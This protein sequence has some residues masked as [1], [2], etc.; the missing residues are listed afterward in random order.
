MD[1]ESPPSISSQ[2]AKSNSSNPSATLFRTTEPVL[3][4]ALIEKKLGLA[5]TWSK[6]RLKTLEIRAD[7]TLWV[8]DPGLS[9]SEDDSEANNDPSASST[10]SSSVKMITQLTSTITNT[11]TSPLQTLASPGLSSTV[12]YQLQKLHLTQM[13]N[14]ALDGNGNE[15]DFGILLDLTSHDGFETKIRVILNEY[16]L[17]DFTQA[18]HLV[19]VDHNLDSVRQLSITEHVTSETDHFNKSNGSNNGTNANNGAKRTKITTTSTHKHKRRTISS[20]TAASASTMRITIAMAMDAVNTQSRVERVVS[21]R[22]V[23]KWLPVYFSNDL[24]H[25]AWYVT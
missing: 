19:A 10:T 24:V 1:I 11:I 7:A 15:R 4:S 6:W 14:N 8:R 25:G 17:H 12:S 22:G 9:S 23:F 5:L 18:L 21:K 3:F 2:K 16:Q 13:N 20:S